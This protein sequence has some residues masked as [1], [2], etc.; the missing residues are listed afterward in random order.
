MLISDLSTFPVSLLIVVLPSK[1]PLEA[2][3]TFKDILGSQF[4]QWIGR[5]Y[6]IF[7]NKSAI[8]FL[9]YKKALDPKAFSENTLQ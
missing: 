3:P 2:Q 1:L 4:K 5:T 9:N 6:A 8:P 7:E